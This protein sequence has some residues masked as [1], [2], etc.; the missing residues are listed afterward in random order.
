M[1]VR[2]V[3]AHF[4]INLDPQRAFAVSLPAQFLEGELDSARVQELWTHFVD[5]VNKRCRVNCSFAGNRHTKRIIFRSAMENDCKDFSRR[6]WNIKVH[7]QVR[8]DD[9]YFLR[10][11]QLTGIPEQVLRAG[12][13]ILAEIPQP[14]V[15]ADAAELLVYGDG[16][17]LVSAVPVD[18]LNDHPS[19]FVNYLGADDQQH[20]IVMVDAALVTS[21]MSLN[22]VDV[23]RI[24]I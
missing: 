20:P 23:E 11:V 14:V 4:T 16:D 13:S 2:E 15:E 5:C 22:R 1:A 9:S 8:G 7:F 12:P 18:I 17:P 10:V 24:Q 6:T 3:K 19:A 21:H